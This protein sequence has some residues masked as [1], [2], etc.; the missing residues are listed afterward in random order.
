MK[1]QAA[2][3]S[4]VRRYVEAVALV[5]IYSALYAAFCIVLG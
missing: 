4:H 5:L 1:C 3:Q 2:P